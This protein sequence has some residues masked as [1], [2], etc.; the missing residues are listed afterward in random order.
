MSEQTNKNKQ[1]AKNT[2]YL[3]LRMFFVLGV[4]LYTTRVV[5]NVLGVVDYGI[6]NVVNGFVLL[7][8]FLNTS[9]ANGVQRFYNYNIGNKKENTVKGS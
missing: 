6:Y 8:S 5:F 2:M 1:I 7:F 3:Y 9:L 4:S